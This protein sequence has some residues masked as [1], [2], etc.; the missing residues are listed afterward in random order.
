MSISKDVT[1]RRS[2]GCEDPKRCEWQRVNYIDP[3]RRTAYEAL[4]L[5]DFHR[6][7]RVRLL[8]DVLRSAGVPRVKGPLFRVWICEGCRAELQIDVVLTI[9]RIA[10]IACARC[11]D[12]VPGYAAHA[13][14][15]KVVRTTGEA[16]GR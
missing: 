8:Q 3:D 2:D 1:R 15:V 13:V 6:E 10:E 14:R 4:R 16:V 7:V 12:I 11:G 9:G 5:C